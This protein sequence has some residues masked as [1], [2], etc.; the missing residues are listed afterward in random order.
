MPS[1]QTDGDPGN[2][3]P[4]ALRDVVSIL[5]RS[6]REFGVPTA[7]RS[8]DRIFARCRAIRNGTTFGHR[9]MDVTTRR[10]TL[11]INEHPWVIAYDPESRSVL[12]IVHASRDLSALFG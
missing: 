4:Q 7:L 3:S 6:M 2:L 12:R 10:P 8:R 9:R 11:F 5:R 1:L